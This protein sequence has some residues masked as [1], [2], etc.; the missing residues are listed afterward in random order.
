MRHFVFA[1]IAICGVGLI[2]PMAHATTTYSIDPATVS[3]QPGDVGD[4]FD[5][6]FTNNGPGDLSVAAFAFEVTVADPDITLTGADFS[7]NAGPY[8]FAGDSFDEINSETLSYVTTV[9]RLPQTVDGSDVTNDA[10]GV[11]VGAGESADLGRVLFDV[12]DPAQAGQFALTFTGVVSIPA[13][14]NDLSD[15]NGVGITPNRLRAVFSCSG[16]MTRFWIRENTH[17][18]RGNDQSGVISRF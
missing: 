5:V 1:F 15:P 16:G 8:I 12:A 2:C 14:A 10:T 9:G 3:A 11:T 7:T 17:G 4:S 18:Y 6:I 13:N